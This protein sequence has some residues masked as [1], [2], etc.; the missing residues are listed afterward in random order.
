MSLQMIG[1]SKCWQLL[2]MIQ[3]WMQKTFPV[4]VCRFFF[5]LEKEFFKKS[6]S[7]KKKNKFW[8]ILM[9]FKW[10]FIFTWQFHWKNS[11]EKLKFAKWLS[12]EKRKSWKN[13]QTSLDIVELRVKFLNIIIWEGVPWK[14]S[15]PFLP[16]QTYRSLKL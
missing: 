10:D 3:D 11:L 4:L 16:A 14:T 7:R 6:F 9:L 12:P 2:V 8:K 1:Q 5:F 15:Y 13:L